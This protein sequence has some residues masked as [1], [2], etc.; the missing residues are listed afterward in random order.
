MDL[1]AT[2]AVELR[3]A[4][5]DLGGR[6][7]SLLQVVASFHANYDAVGNPYG[8][9]WTSPDG[10][11]SLN[12]EDLT[13]EDLQALSGI[14]N[15]IEDP[16]YRARVADVLWVTKKDF[17]AAKVAI[18][19]FLESAERLKP[20]ADDYMWPPYTERLDRAVRISAIRGFGDE[21]VLVLTRIKTAIEE[22]Q[23]DLKSGL[24]CYSLLE[25]L[26]YFRIDKWLEYA[27]LTEALAKGF[28]EIDDWDF[29]NRYFK[30]AAKWYELGKDLDEAKRCLVEA[31]ECLVTCGIQVHEKSSATNAAHWVGRGLEGLRRAGA[32][33][34]RVKEVHQQYLELEK[35]SLADMNPVEVD[36]DQ[37]PDFREQE[38]REQERAAK[39][40]VGH[41]VKTA[42]RRFANMILP[43]KYQNLKEAYFETIKGSIAHQIFGATMLDNFGQVA[44]HV[45]PSY[46]DDQKDN[47]TLRKNL[48]NQAR[49]TN[50]PIMVAWYL[51]PARIAVLEE[52]AIRLSDLRFIV[53]D[54]PF[55]APGHEGIFM[56]GLQAGFHGD[57]LVAINLLVPQIEASIRFILRQNGIVTSKIEQDG[58][59]KEYDLNYLL[60]MPEVDEMLGEDILFDLRGILIER[61]GHNM[62]NESAHGLMREVSFYQPASVYLWWLVLHLCWRGYRIAKYQE[63][64][65]AAGDA[66]DAGID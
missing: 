32:D 46:G 42:I 40:V 11:R 28:T 43:T 22:Y 8:S 66:S 38:V 61:F 34:A 47:E 16:E 56:R 50:W 54:N 24:T 60:W 12:A 9:M 37:I 26:L 17:K 14:V 59:Q 19:A 20:Q 62:R 52:H 48:A 7:F 10:E 4:G 6:V 58:K 45:A 49:T 3:D 35:A 63:R 44:D 30:L 29:A 1:F 2:K 25:L 65:Q 27:V 18:I 55:V 41:S 53:D 57:W 64:Q 23:A 36:L 21:K 13:E 51:E 15:D 31:A 5:D 33:K 39:H